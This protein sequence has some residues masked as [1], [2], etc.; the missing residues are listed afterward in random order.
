[1]KDGSDKIHAE[2]AIPA[3]RF[4]LARGMKTLPQLWTAAMGGQTL[5]RV[6]LRSSEAT[7]AAVKVA[8]PLM[9]RAIAAGKK[10]NDRIDANK[11]C[12]CLRCDFLP[13]CYMASVT[14]D[15]VRFRRTLYTST[16]VHSPQI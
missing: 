1:M 8:D 11:L 15:L 5:H 12:G 3:K 2:G 4:D 9:L 14:A 16:T 10:K 7:R 13:E 6:D